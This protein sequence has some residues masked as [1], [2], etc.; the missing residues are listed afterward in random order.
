MSLMFGCLVFNL[1]W[2]NSQ[3]LARI[4]TDSAGTS[5]IKFPWFI[6]ISRRK[7]GEILINRG[8]FIPEVPLESVC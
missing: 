7:L 2:E 6:Q 4:Y 3:M 8:N 5:G 1:S